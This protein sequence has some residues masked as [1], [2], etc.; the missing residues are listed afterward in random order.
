MSE[1]TPC[2]VHNQEYIPEL[3]DISYGSV[4]FTYITPKGKRLVKQSWVERGRVIGK[5]MNGIP[6][7]FMRMPAPYMGDA[8]NE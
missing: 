2:S 7:A 8:A 4:L 1:W 3:K 5:Q 6:I